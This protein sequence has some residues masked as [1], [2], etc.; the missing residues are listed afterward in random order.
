MTYICA[1]FLFISNQFL[2]MENRL[3]AYLLGGVLT[4]LIALVMIFKLRK[5]ATIRA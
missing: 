3:L 5:D 1:S 2:G 4:L